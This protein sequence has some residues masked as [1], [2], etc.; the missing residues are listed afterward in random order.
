MIIAI[1]C[2][3]KNYAI[4]KDNDLLIS[5]PEDLKKFARLTSKSTV[6]MGRKT[7]ESLPNAPLKNRTNLV[8]SHSANDDAI[9]MEDSMSMVTMERVKEFLLEHRKKIKEL[10]DSDFE[11]DLDEDTV[12]KSKKRKK[13]DPEGK[14]FI[15]GGGEIYKE[16]LPYCDMI[17][18][19]KVFKA[20]ENANV[21]FPNIDN[22]REWEI[23]M[24][25]DVM[26][27]EGIKYQFRR[28]KNNKPMRVKNETKKKK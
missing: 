27:Y 10:K 28:Y 11:D 15:I 5:I 26:E 4:G 3:D 14:I 6:I 9:N 22:M 23:C 25:D 2:A 13:K 17:Y 18:I 16:L 1:V 12:D 19:T 7:Y 24:A 8:I 21:F 20:F